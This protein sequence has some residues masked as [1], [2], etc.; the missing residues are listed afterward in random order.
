MEGRKKAKK[1]RIMGECIERWMKERNE[2]W[3]D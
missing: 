1:E 2:G 3:K